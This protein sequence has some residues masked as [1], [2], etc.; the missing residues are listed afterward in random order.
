MFR[1]SAT[2]QAIKGIFSHLHAVLKPFINKCI[3]IITVV[4]SVRILVNDFFYS[5]DKSVIQYI[6]VE[7]HLMET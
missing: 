1:N 5:T 7:A 6:H 4:E 3:E 2:K